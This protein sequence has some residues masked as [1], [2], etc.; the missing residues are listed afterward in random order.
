M[1]SPETT[2][3]HL[4]FVV[5]CCN[6]GDWDFHWRGSLGHKGISDL[7]GFFFG[8]LAVGALQLDHNFPNL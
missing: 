5:D 6:S 4:I 1:A 8:F 7:G 3:F 2:S